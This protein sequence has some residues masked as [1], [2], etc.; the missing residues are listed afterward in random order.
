M[1][2]QTVESARSL[3]CLADSTGWLAGEP[4]GVLRHERFA[5]DTFPRADLFRLSPP[6]ESKATEPKPPRVEKSGMG[7]APM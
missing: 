2:F 7:V 1:S 3:R 4:T 6:A 5:R